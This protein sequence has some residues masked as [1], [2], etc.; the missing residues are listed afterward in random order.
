MKAFRG[1]TPLK[2]SVIIPAFNER[3]R[4][5][6]CVEEVTRVASDMRVDYEVIVVDDGSGDGTFSVVSEMARRNSR[7]KVVRNYMN[8][9]K[10]CAVK[11]GFQ[12][13]SGDAV[14]YIDADLSISPRRLSSY[15]RALSS[16]DVVIG[17]KRHPK[18]DIVYPLHR[19]ILS[20]CFNIL[21]RVLFRLPLS[22]TQCGFKVFKRRVLEDVVSK[23]RVK[24]YAF[25]VELLI[26]TYMKGYRIVEAP[27]VLRHRERRMS[28]RSIL[29]ML[30][31]LL[32]VFLRVY[33]T[34]VYE[35]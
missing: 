6:R 5:R 18:S 9:G 1:G 29:R 2:L 23:L 16:A 15:L 7:V 25:D 12:H 33:V 19:R 31:D 34:K 32:G 11:K 20:K 30:L 26:L 4:I 27:V 8:E 10:G 28:V 14:A 13:S 35:G 22:D 24:G 17:S 3:G 21:V